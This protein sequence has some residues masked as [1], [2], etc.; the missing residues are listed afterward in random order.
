[1]AAGPSPE[2]RS[3]GAGKQVQLVVPAQPSIQLC[4]NGVMPAQPSIQLCQSGVMPAQAGIQLV[5][6]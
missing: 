5:I 2:R 1:M 4:Q 6:C 3:R